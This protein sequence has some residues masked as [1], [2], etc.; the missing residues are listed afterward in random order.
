[1]KEFT[2]VELK[3]QLQAIDHKL[4]MLK[5]EKVQNELLRKEFNRLHPKTVRKEPKLVHF[6]V[7]TDKGVSYPL[8]AYTYNPKKYATALFE[9][10]GCTV[11]VGELNTINNMEKS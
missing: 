6:H 2:A 5:V 7:I 3:L 11:R 9:E 1:M 10:T 8:T 4:A